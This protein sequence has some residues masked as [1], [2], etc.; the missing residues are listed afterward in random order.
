MDQFDRFSLDLPDRSWQPI[1]LSY[2]C[3]GGIRVTGLWL[4]Q[5]TEAPV[6][7]EST[8]KISVEIVNNTM[9][10]PIQSGLD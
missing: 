8:L 6:C 5:Q 10:F 7:G 3:C 1:K 9:L 2:S 4:F